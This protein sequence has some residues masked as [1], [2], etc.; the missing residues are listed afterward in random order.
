MNN[1]LKIIKS[2]DMAIVSN[3]RFHGYKGSRPYLFEVL[4][5]TSSFIDFLGYKSIVELQNMFS[6]NH[7]YLKHNGVYDRESLYAELPFSNVFTASIIIDEQE[8]D[9]IHGWIEQRFAY[10]DSYFEEL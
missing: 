10:L 6:T 5:I 7:D 9:F 3:A 1:L 8:I 4:E 2:D